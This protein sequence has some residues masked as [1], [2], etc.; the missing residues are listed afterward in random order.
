[1]WQML[2]LS[3]GDA[4]WTFCNRCMEAVRPYLPPPPPPEPEPEPEPE[5]AVAEPIA[6]RPDLLPEPEQLVTAEVEEPVEIVPEVSAVAGS[7]L[8]P[9]LVQPVLRETSFEAAAW[10]ALTEPAAEPEVKDRPAPVAATPEPPSPEPASAPQAADQPAASPAALPAV[11]DRPI[12][13]EATPEPV[14]ATPEPAPELAYE[15]VALEAPVD[16]AAPQPA[17]APAFAPWQFVSVG[18][19][20]EP[21]AETPEAGLPESVQAVAEA[22]TPVR[23]EP[24]AEMHEPSFPPAGPQLLSDTDTHPA[25]PD[26]LGAA[27]GNDLAPQDSLVLNEGSEAA[28]AEED[29]AGGGTEPSFDLESFRRGEPFAHIEAETKPEPAPAPAETAAP[30]EIDQPNEPTI[31]G[32]GPV[33]A[34]AVA[35]LGETFVGESAYV[36]EAG[37]PAAPKAAKSESDELPASEAAYL[38]S[39]PPR[40]EIS[41]AYQTHM[42]ALA[43]PG[44]APNVEISEPVS[45]AAPRAAVE[46]DLGRETEAVPAPELHVST[47]PKPPIEAEPT[48]EHV[49]GSAGPRA[50]TRLAGRT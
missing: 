43:E 11:A 15:P 23:E 5:L 32:E 1:M 21:E 42:D 19:D 50:S 41:A 45:Q 20:F 49:P 25:T 47:E 17:S 36:Y 48:A 35:P 31:A 7:L 8:Q 6:S 27:E 34:L 4:D 28:I 24:P 44:V 9:G 3:E 30:L 38:T 33:E 14:P 2:L 12:S 18:D 13:L 10:R 39:P 40:A 29:E 26:V 37:E 22:P 16:T 46:A